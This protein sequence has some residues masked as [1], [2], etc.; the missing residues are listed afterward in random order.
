MNI[1]FLIYAAILFIASII[2][3]TIGQLMSDKQKK[4]DAEPDEAETPKWIRVF[5][6][7]GFALALICLV[8]AFKTLG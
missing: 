2:V 1:L 4:E 8:A 6:G 7:V 5:A 3:F